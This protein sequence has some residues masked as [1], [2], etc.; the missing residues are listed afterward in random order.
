[1]NSKIMNLD[2][3]DLGRGLIVALI[4]GFALPILAAI[5][6]PNFDVFAANW[7]AI[8]TLAINGAVAAFAS[9][10]VKNIFSDEDGKFLGKV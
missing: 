3:K 8:L 6:T 10:I 7:S 9:Y 5:Q 2:W 4:G 1:M